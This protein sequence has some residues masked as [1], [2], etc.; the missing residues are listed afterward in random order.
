MFS[1]AE[2]NFYDLIF[3]MNTGPDRRLYDGGLVFT[4]ITHFDNI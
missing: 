1:L 2:S 4:V 3:F